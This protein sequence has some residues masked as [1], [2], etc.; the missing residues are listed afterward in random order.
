MSIPRNIIFSPFAKGV[1]SRDMSDKEFYKAGYVYY[2]LNGANANISSDG[3]GTTGAIKKLGEKLGKPYHYFNINFRIESDGNETGFSSTGVK[4]QNTPYFFK[5]ENKE[6][7]EKTQIAG[8]FHVYGKDFR[9]SHTDKSRLENIVAVRDYYDRIIKA[10]NRMVLGKTKKYILYLARVPGNI[11]KGG[12]ETVIGMIQAINGLKQEKNLTYQI[13]VSRELY[14][15]VYDYLFFSTPN[16]LKS[17]YNKCSDESPDSNPENKLV[18]TGPIKEAFERSTA[19][20]PFVHLYKGTVYAEIDEKMSIMVLHVDLQATPTLPKCEHI[21]NLNLLNDDCSERQ[22]LSTPVIDGSSDIKLIDEKI[23]ICDPLYNTEFKNRKYDMLILIIANGGTTEEIVLTKIVLDEQKYTKYTLDTLLFLTY[24]APYKNRL[25]NIL[26][27]LRYVDGS[28]YKGAT[29]QYQRSD[30][31]WFENMLKR[32]KEPFKPHITFIQE[33][34]KKDFTSNPTT[35]SIE[36]LFGNTDF[37][38]NENAIIFYENKIMVYIINLGKKFSYFVKIDNVTIEFYLDKK[39]EDTFF[40]IYSVRGVGNDKICIYKLEYRDVFG[41]VLSSPKSKSEP[42]LELETNLKHDDVPPELE[43]LQ[44]SHD[45]LRREKE[46][47]LTTED[48]FYMVTDRKYGQKQLIYNDPHTNC[49]KSPSKCGLPVYICVLCKK[50]IWYHKDAQYE[51]VADKNK[52]DCSI[53]LYVQNIHLC[54]EKEKRG[55][56]S[57]LNGI[58][59]LKVSFGDD[60]K[61]DLGTLEKVD[62]VNTFV[63]SVDDMGESTLYDT[64]NDVLVIII[65][66]ISTKEFFQI[67]FIGEDKNKNF[68]LRAVKLTNKH[69]LIQNNISPAYCTLNGKFSLDRVCSKILWYIRFLIM[70][71]SPYLRKQETVPMML[72]RKKS[73]VKQ[74]IR[75]LKKIKS[76]KSK[77]KKSLSPKPKK[78]KKSKPKK[79]LKSPR[80]KK[81]NKKG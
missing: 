34:F 58:I 66:A 8:V 56:I 16:T 70:Q 41:E 81:S 44:N 57:C 30:I 69:P 35:S 20:L 25:Q 17:L 38:K 12:A 10:V 13:D 78:P 5:E 40:G 64:L 60:I 72:F 11:F 36:D 27:K 54:D 61:L 21:L 74:T 9:Q 3:I 6:N 67:I 42:K 46:A 49:D 31:R 45:F 43:Q 32:Y 63:V 14:Y 28:R 79:S 19:G 75:S 2:L 76:K 7:E 47:T 24:N 1:K 55:D 23:S 22:E 33:V 51:Y 26:E 65:N 68:S 73:K 52:C 53:P 50:Q 15:L 62:G 39:E 48:L 29:C 59:D 77:P 80:L 18:I 71:S 4:E 37:L